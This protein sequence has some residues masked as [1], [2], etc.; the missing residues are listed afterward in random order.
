M[1]RLH[2]LKPLTHATEIGAIN[3]TPDSSASFSCRRSTSDV[4]DPKAVDDVRSRT[5][6]RKT[7]AGILGLWHRFLERVS[8]A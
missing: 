7:G 5:S 4:I 1:A 2:N 6:A 3:S 8:G